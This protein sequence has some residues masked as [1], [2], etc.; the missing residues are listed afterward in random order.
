M[1]QMPF[2]W[3]GGGML[4]A[5]VVTMTCGDGLQLYMEVGAECAE[6]EL[7]QAPTMAKPRC[8]EPTSLALQ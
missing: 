5:E 7:L 4:P 1:D 3:L 6:T 2:H 8:E